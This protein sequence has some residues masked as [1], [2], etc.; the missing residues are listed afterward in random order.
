MAE[1]KADEVLDAARGRTPSSPD[2]QLSRILV[3][4]RLS[5]CVL[6]GRFETSLPD[7]APLSPAGLG[8]VLRG[9]LA[10]SEAVA[11]SVSPAVLLERKKM[12]Y[13]QRKI[14][15]ISIILVTTNPVRLK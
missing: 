4:G 12:F 15:K 8:D 6:R 10:A 14:R 13:K 7:S 9:R 3:V 5:L 1:G 11:T 2:S